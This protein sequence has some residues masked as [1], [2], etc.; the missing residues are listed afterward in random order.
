MM[1]RRQ[2]ETAGPLAELLAGVRVYTDDH[3]LVS[4]EF[5]RLRAGVQFKDSHDVLFQTAIKLKLATL[6]TV[7]D[8]QRPDPFRRAC[9]VQIAK[10]AWWPANEG[11]QNRRDLLALPLAP[12]AEATLGKDWRAIRGHAEHDSKR[13]TLWHDDPALSFS[14]A[15]GVWL[16]RAASVGHEGLVHYF[17]YG[18]KEQQWVEALEAAGLKVCAQGEAAYRWHFKVPG[19]LG[20]PQ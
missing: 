5:G 9:R 4:D 18:P 15:R 14:P 2:D 3:C 6:L 20:G 19:L 12:A 16:G 11:L 1:A 13:T 17:V 10:P 8:W 7:M